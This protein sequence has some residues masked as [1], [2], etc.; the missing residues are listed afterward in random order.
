MGGLWGPGRVTGSTAEAGTTPD[1][2]GVIVFAVKWFCTEPTR[3]KC[4]QQQS[5]GNF[6]SALDGLLSLLQNY[7]KCTT[8]P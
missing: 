8:A 7:P 2:G 6:S 4:G 1:E 5:L 3:I